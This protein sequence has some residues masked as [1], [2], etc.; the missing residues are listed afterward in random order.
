MLSSLP[1]GIGLSLILLYRILWILLKVALSSIPITW[2]IHC[3]LSGIVCLTVLLSWTWW[4]FIVRSASGPTSHSPS[5]YSSLLAWAHPCASRADFLLFM[6][7]NNSHTATVWNIWLEG[8][9]RSSTVLNWLIALLL[10]RLPMLIIIDLAH[11]IKRIHTLNLML[12]YFVTRWV[13]LVLNLVCY[14]LLWRSILSSHNL[15]RSISKWRK[16]RLW[17]NLLVIICIILVLVRDL[18]LIEVIMRSTGIL[19]SRN[20]LLWTTVPDY[21]RIVIT[22]MLM[23]VHTILSKPL[24][25]T[26]SPLY[27][28]LRMLGI[29]HHVMWLVGRHTLALRWSL[30][31]RSWIASIPWWRSWML[32]S[33]TI[34]A[35][36]FT[37]LRVATLLLSR[38]WA[39]IVSTGAFSASSSN[40]LINFMVYLT[41][42]L[43]INVLWCGSWSAW[44]TILIHRARAY[45]L[46]R[47]SLM[48]VLGILIMRRS[49]LLTSRGVGMALMLIA[50]VSLIRLRRKLAS[51]LL[52]VVSNLSRTMAVVRVVGM[53]GI[54]AARVLWLLLFTIFTYQ[55]V[56]AWWVASSIKLLLVS[57][58]LFFAGVNRMVATHRTLERSDPSS[59]N[60]VCVGSPSRTNS[61]RTA[62]LRSLTVITGLFLI[63]E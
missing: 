9:F 30:V 43:S 33:T 32:G 23:V 20:G 3:I 51:L 4:S 57:Q 26:R 13:I 27:M 63:G 52:S 48:G 31:A 21:K 55:I 28:L 44:T 1:V 22:K 50:M 10:L 59:S 16:D 61:I 40:I 39:S 45:L 7:L 54:L 56:I 19:V 18:I 46:L 58:L 14:L 60:L 49:L 47:A 5:A 35:L 24:L 53:V 36:I 8:W 34:V 2:L 17:I 42:V 25:N 37:V 6:L 62:I 12:L 11:S 15:N 38:G 29:A 41:L